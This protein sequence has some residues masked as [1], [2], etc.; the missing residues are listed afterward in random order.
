MLTTISPSFIEEISQI[1]ERN[2]S[3]TINLRQELNSKYSFEN[4]FL[5]ITNQF[6]N[7]LSFDIF[8]LFTNSS[9]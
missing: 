7:D 4:G 5:R 8:N 2:S 9:I 3:K 1:I 6:L